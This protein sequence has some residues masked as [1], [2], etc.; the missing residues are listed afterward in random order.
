MVAAAAMEEPLMAAKPPQAKIVAIAVPP[1]RCPTQALAARNNSRLIPDTLTTAPIRMNM[2]MTLK[3]KLVTV[4][5]GE[6][7]RMPS[8]GP[9]PTR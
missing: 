4:R 9:G 5:I 8:A 2:G 6:L 3:L 1:G 7:I